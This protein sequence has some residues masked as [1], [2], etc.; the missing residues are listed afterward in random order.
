M[1]SGVDRRD[2]IN[3]SG[4]Y[5]EI[6]FNMKIPFQ[7]TFPELFIYG[8]QVPTLTIGRGT[9]MRCIQLEG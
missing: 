9:A 7:K 8:T 1:D 6:N 3:H 4:R 5:T 2:H